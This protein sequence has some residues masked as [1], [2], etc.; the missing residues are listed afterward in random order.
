LAGAIEA[1]ALDALRMRLREV[2]EELGAFEARFGCDFDRFAA[3]W[4]SGRLADRSSHRA[5]RDY[6]EWEALAMER[7]ELLELIREYADPAH[8]AG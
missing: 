4:E 6:M 2:V 5:E 3:D 1:V 7:R 8:V